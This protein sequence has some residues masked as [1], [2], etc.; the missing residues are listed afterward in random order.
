MRIPGADNSK[1][2]FGDRM[3][4]GKQDG[5]GCMQIH[6]TKAKQTVFAINSWR[7]GNNACL[8]IGNQKTNH[9][10]WTF[11]NN[12]KQYTVKRLRVLVLP[13]Q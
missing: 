7:S 11:A 10:D 5:Y 4:K 1:Y 6:L 2:D 13:A 9:P 12:G 3:D 8:G